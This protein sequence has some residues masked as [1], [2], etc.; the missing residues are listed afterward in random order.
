MFEPREILISPLHNPPKGA[1][2]H[3]LHGLHSTYNWDIQSRSFL[4][5]FLTRWERVLFIGTQ[6]SILYTS[7][8]SPAE[9]LWRSHTICNYRWGN[10]QCPP[11]ICALGFGHLPFYEYTPAIIMNRW[12][13]GRSDRG[14]NYLGKRLYSNST[15]RTASVLKHTLS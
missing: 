4:I 2:V 7:M 13:S 1:C 12:K 8:Y 9:T 3:I 11:C 15:S 10:R 6:F 14:R 5:L